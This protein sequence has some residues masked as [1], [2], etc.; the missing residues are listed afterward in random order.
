MKILE[1]ERLSAKDIPDTGKSAKEKM[2]KNNTLDKTDFI[3]PPSRLAANIFK[4]TH[5]N[6]LSCLSTF[7]VEILTSNSLFTS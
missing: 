4:Y 5:Y 7:F 3:R 1:L 6:I 2:K